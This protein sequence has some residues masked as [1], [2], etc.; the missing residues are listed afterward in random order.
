MSRSTY[1]P[2]HLP[3]PPFLFIIFLLSFFPISLPLNI[4]LPISYMHRSSP[5]PLLLSTCPVLPVSFYCFLCS[6]TGYPFFHSCC[7]YHFPILSF[8]SSI[9]PILSFLQLFFIFSFFPS[10]PSLILSL[11]YPRSS[12]SSP[13]HHSSNPHNEGN[14]I[15]LTSRCNSGL[16]LESNYCKTDRSAI[17]SP[18]ST[19]VFCKGREECV[20]RR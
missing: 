3:A 17:F 2:T 14:S 16:S 6:L 20:E 10:F 4:P 7:P 9:L 8:P 13:C 5:C 11:S 12:S 19:L 18:I 1:T 15:S